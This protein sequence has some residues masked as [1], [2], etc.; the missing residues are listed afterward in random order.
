[1]QILTN[2]NITCVI[3]VFM[4]L[5][6]SSKDLSDYRVDLNFK[7]SKIIDVLTSIEKQT[8][9][10][11]VYSSSSVKENKLVTID[12]KQHNLSE[13]LFIITNDIP[14]DFTLRGNEIIFTKLDRIIKGKVFDD[15]KNPL[16]GASIVAS[17]SR[18]ATVTDIEGN[19]ELKLKK[20]DD[21]LEFSFVGLEKQEVKINQRTNIEVSLNEE[22]IGLSEVV[23]VGYG[24]M[25]KKDMTGAVSSVSSER[26]SQAGTVSVLEAMQGHVAGANISASSGKAGAGYN[27]EIRGRNSLQSGGEPLYVVDGVM[28]GSISWLNPADIQRIDVLKDASSTAIYGSRGT[29]GVVM[30]TTKQAPKEKGKATIQYDA[31][32]GIREVARMPEFMSG[33]EWWEFRRNSFLYESYYKKGKEFPTDEAELLAIMDYSK[34]EIYKDNVDN[35]RTFDWAGALQQTGMQMNHYISVSGTSENDLS[36]VFGVGYQAEE[37]NVKNDRQDKYSIKSKVSQQ[38]TKHWKSGINMN[39]SMRENTYNKSSAYSNAFRFSPF[40]SPYDKEGELLL[41]PAKYDGMSLTSSTNPLLYLEEYIDESIKIDGIASVYLQFEPIDDLQFRATYS[42]RIYYRRKGSYSSPK[43][44]SKGVSSATKDHD[45]TIAGDFEFRT[46]YQLKLSNSRLNLL[47]VFS[48]YQ[49]ESESSDMEV[50]NLPFDSEY[51]NLGNA[52]Q[53]EWREL[54][55]YYSKETTLSYTLRANYSLMDRYLLTITNRWDGSSKLSDDKKWGMFPSAAI[56]WRVT[57]EAFMK[58]ID[59]LSNLKIRLSYGLTGNTSSLSR[60]ATQQLASSHRYYGFGDTMAEGFAPGGMANPNLI[61][62]KSNELNLGVE[63]GFFKGKISGSIELYDKT[64]EDL[65]YKRELPFETGYSS[66]YQNIGSVNNKG[67]ELSL[68][69][70]NLKTNELYWTT[71]FT[72]SKNINEIVDIYG[73]KKDDIGNKLFIGESIRSNWTYTLDGIWTV[74]EKEEAAKYG[75][76]PGEARA[77]DKNKDGKIDNDDKSIIGTK[78]PSW[79]L[80]FNT[81]LTY[82][83]FDFSLSLNMVEGTQVWSGFIKDFSDTKDRGRQKIKVDYYMMD[84]PITGARNGQQAPSPKANQQY[85]SSVS[86][87][88]DASY[89]KVKNISLGYTL[90]KAIVNKLKVGKLRLYFNVLNPIVVTDFKG[91]DPEWAN[92]GTDGGSNSYITYQFGLNLSL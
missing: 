62:E 52:P 42:P 34:S 47:G 77:V 56:A 18:I 30:V 49:S 17:K 57:E 12:V 88:V 13:V 66:L 82:K 41:Q 81:N 44:S 20:L 74:D 69:T 73:D 16:P 65:H 90:P 38:I 87:Y 48:S 86:G 67:V 24:T 21:V 7:K 53:E 60:Y 9:L 58:G 5:F 85:Y 33:E 15:S 29:N 25:K 76:L 19:F 54:D 40:V 28:V 37:S 70:A 43:L 83:G 50:R 39:L 51:H 89:I 61:W 6:I 36:Y 35:N 55:S 59:F 23:V 45:Q 2:K 10:T 4:S 64:S 78:D 71:G 80:G 91:F 22:A 75:Q 27:I 11:F 72:F 31:Y 92:T 3:L 68:K 14:V 46:N 26:I 8:N 63:Y 79:T 32:Y 84:N 1:M